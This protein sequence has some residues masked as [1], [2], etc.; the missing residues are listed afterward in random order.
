M[1]LQTTKPTQMR[2][3]SCVLSQPKRDKVHEK[4]KNRAY[5]TVKI[6]NRP[7]NAAVRVANVRENGQPRRN[8]QLLGKYPLRLSPVRVQS[9]FSPNIIRNFIEYHLLKLGA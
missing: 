4:L 9:V 2:L 7:D 1:T 3:H 8:T 6:D 5:V